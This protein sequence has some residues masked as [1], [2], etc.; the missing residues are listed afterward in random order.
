MNNF[1][2]VFGNS[3]AFSVSCKLFHILNWKP[4]H[5]RKHKPMNILGEIFVV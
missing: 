5:S 1:S 3:G 4:A 2:F